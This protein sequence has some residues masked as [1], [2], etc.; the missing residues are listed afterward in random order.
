MNLLHFVVGEI[1]NCY[2]IFLVVPLLDLKLFMAAND[3][4]KLY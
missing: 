3:N 4:P 1:K 2:S